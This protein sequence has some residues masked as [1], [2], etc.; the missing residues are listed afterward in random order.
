MAAVGSDTESETEEQ[1]E[2]VDNE[3]ALQEI[4]EQSVVEDAESVQIDEDEYV[5]VDV[6]DNDYYTHDDDEEHMFAQ[7]KEYLVTYVKVDRHP[8]WMLW[9]SGSTTTGIMPQFVHVNTIRVHELMELVML[10]L[11][12]MGSCAVIQFGVE[13]KMKM[14][15][16][17]MR[18]YVDIANFNCYDM[19]IGMLFMCKNKVS[20]DFLNNKVVVNRVPLRAE[21]IVLADMDGHL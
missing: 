16:L 8:A 13:V 10:Q 18:E 11:G 19:I 2:L 20:L 17:P 1:G 6:Y 7:E 4:E 15:G 21:K 9:D 14:S 3:E 12:T 5:A